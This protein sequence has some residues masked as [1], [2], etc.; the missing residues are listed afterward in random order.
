MQASLGLFMLSSPPSWFDTRVFFFFPDNVSKNVESFFFEIKVKI[1]EQPVFKEEKNFNF[2]LQ[3]FSIRK[4]S[5]PKYINLN[6]K[7]FEGY[8]HTHTPMDS[9]G[10]GG[11]AKKRKKKKFIKYI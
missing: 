4:K 10:V 7:Q 1:I 9:K 2:E 8:N 5:Q 3:K 6:N 11:G